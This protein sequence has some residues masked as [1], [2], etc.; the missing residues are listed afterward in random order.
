MN[1]YPCRRHCWIDGVCIL[2]GVGQEHR[3]CYSEWHVC[4]WYEP[5]EW[6]RPRAGTW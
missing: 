3:H 6:D 5:G 4:A 2:C 1:R